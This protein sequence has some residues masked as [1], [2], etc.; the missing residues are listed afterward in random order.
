M[1]LQ[2][3]ETPAYEALCTNLS[4]STPKDLFDDVM[5]DIDKKVSYILRLYVI[6][7]NS[8]QTSRVMIDTQALI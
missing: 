3:K 7:C 2:L 1:H 8:C 4:G 6:K 5:E